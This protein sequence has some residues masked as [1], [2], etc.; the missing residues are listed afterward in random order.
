MTRALALL[1]MV[2]AAACRQAPAPTNDSNLGADTMVVEETDTA[3]ENAA[4]PPFDP[5]QSSI[6]RGF[7]DPDVTDRARHVSF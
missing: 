6:Q 7:R 2:A 4:T 3:M 1:L 5:E